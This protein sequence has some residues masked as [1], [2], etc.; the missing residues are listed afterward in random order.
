MLHTGTSMYPPPVLGVH[1]A[2]ALTMSNILWEN[3]PHRVRH[4]RPRRVHVTELNKCNVP[5]VRVCRLDSCVRL[6]ACACV[7]DG[8]LGVFSTSC[9]DRSARS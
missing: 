9:S 2:I 3:S 8:A 4:I 1:T 7:N 6:L 5:I